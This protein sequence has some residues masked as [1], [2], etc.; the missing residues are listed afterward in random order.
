M[1]E[2]EKPDPMD[3]LK[4]EPIRIGVAELADREIP[5][6]PGEGTEGGELLAQ[7]DSTAG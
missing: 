1:S 6:A 2:P 5:P 4:R 7:G 3:G